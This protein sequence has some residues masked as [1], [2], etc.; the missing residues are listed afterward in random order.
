M[1]P[2]HAAFWDSADHRNFVENLNIDRVEAL[3]DLM[4]VSAMIDEILSTEEREDVAYA[5][6]DLPGVPDEWTRFDSAAM[7]DHVDHLYVRHA[8]DGDH[9]LEELFVRIGDAL[10]LSHALEAVVVLL[11]TNR[12]EPGEA[13]FIRRLGVLMDVQDEFVENLLARY[14]W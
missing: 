2:D 12:R 3:R 6:H 14:G 4:I 5:L 11:A 13:Q 1:D 9:L 7:V 10:D 8:R